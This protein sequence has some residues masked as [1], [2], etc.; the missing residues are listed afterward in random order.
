MAINKQEDCFGKKIALSEHQ[1]QCLVIKWATTYR[2]NDCKEFLISYLI[3]IPNG[4]R[5]NLGVAMKLKMEGVKSGVSDLFL[6]IPSR[7][8]SGLWIEMKRKGL[9]QSSM[10][11]SQKAWLHRMK[12]IGYS[13]HMCAGF[14]AAR[15]VII[16]YLSDVH[17]DY[18]CL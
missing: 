2:I 16:N 18:I 5:R 9:T 6:A 17:F 8:Y 11:D 10:L 12:K 4:G 15:D 14:E 1:E 13:G 7:K 3:S